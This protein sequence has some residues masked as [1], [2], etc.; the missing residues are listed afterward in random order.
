M[1]TWWYYIILILAVGIY[2]SV[3]IFMRLAAAHPFLSGIYIAFVACAV[4][5][6]GLYAVIW[7]QILGRMNLGLA[8]V[9]RGLGILFTLLICHF[10][11]SETITMNNMVGA[12]LIVMGIILFAWMDKKDKAIE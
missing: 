7:Q 5:V 3:G 4:A 10:V 2:S 6:L 12:G 9:F 1:R 11:F 8:F